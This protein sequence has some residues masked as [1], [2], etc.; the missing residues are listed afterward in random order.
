MN[1]EERNQKLDKILLCAIQRRPGWSCVD[2]IIAAPLAQCGDCSFEEA[3]EEAF[4]G[5]E[6]CP[7]ELSARA[8]DYCELMEELDLSPERDTDKCFLRRY[9]DDSVGLITSGDSESWLS[10]TESEQDLFQRVSAS[11]WEELGY[12]KFFE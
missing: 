2:R 7:Q 12:A 11:D 6:T 4:P 3:A 8:A 1:S 9:S 5:N 10:A